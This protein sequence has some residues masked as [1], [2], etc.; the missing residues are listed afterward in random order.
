[1][2]LRPTLRRSLAGMLFSAVAATGVVALTPTV[3]GASV[4][5]WRPDAPSCTN[6]SY[7]SWYDFSDL[8]PS[9]PC[10]PGATEIFS[11]TNESSAVYLDLTITRW[12]QASGSWHKQM[13]SYD[14]Y[15]VRCGHVD[16]AH[17]MFDNGDCLDFQHDTLWNGPYHCLDEGVLGNVCGYTWESADSRAFYIQPG[18]RYQVVKTGWWVSGGR[19]VPKTATFWLDDGGFVYSTQYS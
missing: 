6:Q 9:R 19:W 10:T 13:M 12:W 7:G 1:M 3:A 14:R 11:A 15:N 4:G 18:E 16:V 17:Y 5:S 8:D 2:N